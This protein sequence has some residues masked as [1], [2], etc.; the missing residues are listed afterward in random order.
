MFRVCELYEVLADLDRA[1]LVATPLFIVFFA[2]LTG[3]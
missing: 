1:R 3:S 2:K